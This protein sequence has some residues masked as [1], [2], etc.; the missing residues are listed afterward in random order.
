MAAIGLGPILAAVAVEEGTGRVEATIEDH[1]QAIHRGVLDMAGEEEATRAVSAREARDTIGPTTTAIQSI[2]KDECL[3][4]C[5]Y[6]NFCF[7]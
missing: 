4:Y 2:Q 5:F 7:N 6:L 3:I 1:L